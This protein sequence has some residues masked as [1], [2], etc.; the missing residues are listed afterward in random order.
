MT[1]QRRTAR[2]ATTKPS[3]G[4]RRRKPQPHDRVKGRARPGR[5]RRAS[6]ASEQLG[7]GPRIL[8]GATKVLGRVVLGLLIL[9]IFIFGVFPT[10]SYVEQRNELRDAEAELAE[11]REENAVLQTR[12][13]RLGSD[14]EIEL[15][16]REFGLVRPVEEN[17][18]IIAPGN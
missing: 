2:G 15:E 12:I 17:Y 18:L 1:V 5:E 7:L 10:G 8:R 14:S 9:A 13:E 11:L 6:E 3:P 16:A 4:P